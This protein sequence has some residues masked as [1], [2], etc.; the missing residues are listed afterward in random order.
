MDLKSWA[1]HK[2]LMHFL[3]CA[4]HTE[5]FFHMSFGMLCFINWYCVFCLIASL[6]KLNWQKWLAHGVH[7]FQWVFVKGCVPRS[8]RRWVIVVFFL[9]RLVVT[10]GWGR[11]LVRSIWETL[12][13]LHN[14][15]AYL[16]KCAHAN[17]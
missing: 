6:Q 17:A 5:G 4:N 7:G 12:V 14:S 11:V 3:I 13:R 16:E 8:S 1:A 2:H 10:P 15:I 9:R